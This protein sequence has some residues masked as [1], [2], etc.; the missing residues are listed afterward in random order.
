MERLDF[1]MTSEASTDYRWCSVDSL[2]AG[3]LLAFE[4]MRIDTEPQRNTMRF[5]VNLQ[6]PMV[7]CF[8]LAVSAQ[9]LC[10]RNKVACRLVLSWTET[11]DFLCEIDT[12]AWRICTA[13]AFCG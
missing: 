7:S 13:A 5:H 3:G 12:V 4:Q 10:L 6:N 8:L 1:Q 9:W 2:A 11:E